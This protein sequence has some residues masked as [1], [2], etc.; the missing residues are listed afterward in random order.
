MCINL[1]LA[2]N[3]A[4]ELSHGFDCEDLMMLLDSIVGMGP[5]L[6]VISSGV[7]SVE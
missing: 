6:D 1:R 2:S 4:A 5:E 3:V 7:G